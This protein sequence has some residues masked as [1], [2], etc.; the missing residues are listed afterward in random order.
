MPSRA[1]SAKRFAAS[2]SACVENRPLDPHLPGWH[3]PFSDVLR[4]YRVSLGRC[5]PR[6]LARPRP[7]PRRHR[8]RGPFTAHPQRRRGVKRS[9]PR[10]GRPGVHHQARIPDSTRTSSKGSPSVACSDS[11]NPDSV[12]RLVARRPPRP[13]PI[14][15]LRPDPHCVV[16]VC[17]S[18]PNTDSDRYIGPSTAPPAY[19]VLVV[20]NLFDPAT[21]YQGAVVA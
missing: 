1:D 17:A 3:H 10:S 4:P 8:S 11:D 14:R 2:P 20:G 6:R 21:P 19:P 13:R 18:G 9:K 12:R 7:V 16:P 5:T 15:L